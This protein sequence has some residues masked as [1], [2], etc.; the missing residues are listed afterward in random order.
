M[1]EKITASKIEKHKLFDKSNGKNILRVKYLF[2]CYK[3]CFE[4]WKTKQEWICRNMMYIL[5]DVSTRTFYDT[6][7]NA[8]INTFSS[9]NTTWSDCHLSFRKRLLL[10]KI[11]IKFRIDKLNICWLTAMTKR[12]VLPIQEIERNHNYFS[13]IISQVDVTESP[14]NKSSNS[15][16]ISYTKTF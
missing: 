6:K 13:T 11:I 5:N 1:V 2:S 3:T 15:D 8:W 12:F 9:I 7:H 4:V 16:I 10:K 14:C